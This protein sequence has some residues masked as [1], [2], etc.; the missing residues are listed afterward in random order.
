M[1]WAEAALLTAAY[2]DGELAAHAASRL[3]RAMERDPALRAWIESQGRFH[4]FLRRALADV[5][6]PPGFAQRLRK[7]LDEEPV[8]PPDPP[9]K[10]HRHLSL[11]ASR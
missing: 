4:E 11:T 1:T 8:P 10:S 3:L 7:R 6:I 5:P 9:G 2:L